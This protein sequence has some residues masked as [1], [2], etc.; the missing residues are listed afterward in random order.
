MGIPSG[1]AA[2][3]GA[4][5]E[6]VYGTPAEASK[7]F[8][9]IQES[10]KLDVKRMES[11]AI[12]AGTRVMRSDDW[13]PGERAVAGSL[14]LELSTKGLGFWLGH[15]FGSVVTSQP[16]VGASPTVYKHT[17]VPGDLPG[18]FTVQVGRPTTA[19]VVEPFT[20][21]GCQVKD[22]ELGVDVGGIATL[23]LGIIGRD[24]LLTEDLAEPVYPTGSTLLSFVRGTVTV[25]GSPSSIK[26]FSVKGVT[27]LDD[28]RYAIGSALRDEPLENDLRDIS[29]S[30]EAEFD[31]TVD[32]ARF[33][34]GSEAEIVLELQGPVI[35][36]AIRYSIKI[37]LNARFDGETPSVG[38][39]GVVQR[40]V[41]FKVVDNGTLSARVE[42]T[43]TDVLP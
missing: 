11:A 18:T 30:F 14:D 15:S 19:G 7:F 28:A 25:G 31:S 39:R 32:Y 17:F 16:D 37:T 35:E 3:V 12:R 1:L 8:E 43:T 9:F 6:T 27:G 22:W 42:Y 29:G 26:K 34:A 13:L 33:V 4:A 40:S 2:Q 36:D 20:Y 38:D 23:K 10:L 21:T 5:D 41:P 24:E